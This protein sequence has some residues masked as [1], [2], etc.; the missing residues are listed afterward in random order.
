MKQQSSGQTNDAHLV[1]RGSIRSHRCLRLRH[2]AQTWDAFS[3]SCIVVVI[4]LYAQG[5]NSL[6]CIG[7]QKMS[8]EAA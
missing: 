2:L 6:P 8:I 3:T 4:F 7:R 5:H 1:Q